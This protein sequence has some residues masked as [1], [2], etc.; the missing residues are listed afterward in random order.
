MAAR[1]TPDVLP[2]SIRR[3]V[4]SA[5]RDIP[6]F[7]RPGITFKD[8]TPLLADA[9]AFA[10]AIDVM[11][12]PFLGSVDHVAGIEAR[13]FI[14][15]SPVAYHLGAGLIPM[16]KAGK[17]PAP[18]YAQ[19]YELEY[20]SET[21]EIHRDALAQGR[22]VLIVDDVLAT[23]GTAEVAA[24]LVEEAGGEVIGISVLLEL[25]SLHGRDKLAGRPVH[26]LL[27]V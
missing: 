14:L 8:I 21:L 18:T 9:A 27:A 3:L 25:A 2:T 7:P 19:S 10:Q 5:I 6:D 20:G 4:A 24:S 11:A 22:K 1:R 23:G 17:L 12:R 16:R 15:A 26:T 13:G